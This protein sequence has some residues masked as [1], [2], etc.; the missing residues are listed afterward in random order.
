MTQVTGIVLHVGDNR[1]L[2]IHMSVGST[3]Q[4]VTVDG[5]GITINTTDASVGAVVD[6]K[7]IEEI[8][9]N[10]RSFNSL[11]MLLPGVN[12]TSPQGNDDGGGFSSNGGRTSSN[13]Y[14]L[15][16]ASAMNDA[17][18]GGSGRGTTGSTS[19]ST[20]LGTTQSII[21]VDALQEFRIAT[22][23]YSAEFGRFSGAQISFT[24]R[25]GTN[26]YHGTA[27]DYLRNYA[28][29]ANDWFNTYS[30]PALPRPTER[31]NDFGGVFGGPLSI[32]KLFSGRNR[33]FFFLSYEGL[34]L[35]KPT[36]STIVYVP[37]NGT[38]NTSTAYTN[39]AYKD[40]R[41]NAGT[42]A[43]PGST[44]A[45][46]TP[47]LKYILNGFPLPNCSTAINPQC[48]D[49]AD[50]LSPFLYTT[51]APSSINSTSARIDFQITSGLHV[52]ARYSDTDSSDTALYYGSNLDTSQK[53]HR[54]YLL[55]VDSTLSNSLANQLRV[56]Y[57]PAFSVTKTTSKSVAGS[58]P[59][60]GQSGTNFQNIQGLPTV[61]GKSAFEMFFPS[62]S[63]NSFQVPHL[64]YLS[65]GSRQFQ[66]YASDALTWTHG[67]HLFKM[68]VDYRQTTARLGIPGIS[69]GPL[70]Y[71]NMETA[72]Q[73]LQNSLYS[74][75][76]SNIL[77]QD[78]RTKNLGIYLQDE[79]HILP[80]LS[81]SLGLRY[82][83]NPPPTVSGAQQYTYTGDINN[84]ASLKL[85]TLGAPLYK[86]T[87]TNFAP[88][89]GAAYIIHNQTG[90]E[91]VLR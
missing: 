79:W 54:A 78:P 17:G 6:R 1:N 23:T 84:P 55:G 77:R 87:Y 49:Y 19:S 22:S 16:G 60:G 81:L 67:N 34:R 58:Q 80:R 32:P 42:T 48:V 9:L 7:F 56:Q 75:T 45:L 18:N 15:D 47:A 37:S 38:F 91:T 62:I 10:G 13:S 83:F 85:S 14:S 39:P 41:D 27:F 5:S 88:R 69:Y 72:D 57:S 25:S 2:V 26:S 50:G 82:D 63:A 29:D 70:V 12:S 53:R 90:H 86:T 68:G 59:V 33:A 35:Q 30:T 40:L 28:F 76:S 20:A 4:S 71:Y 24:S 21:S 66:P 65:N 74:V 36:Y 46:N 31:Q 3:A 73:V 44:G 43:T 52:F 11:I 51:T 64:F 61:G 8:P 89:L